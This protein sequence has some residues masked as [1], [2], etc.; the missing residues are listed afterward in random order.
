[1]AERLKATKIG[2]R[3]LLLLDKADDP[4][5]QAGRRRDLLHRELAQPA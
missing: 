1:M 5:A 3:R 2:E 4:I